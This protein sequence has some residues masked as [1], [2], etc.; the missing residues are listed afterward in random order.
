V[1]TISHTSRDAPRVLH[2]DFPV[3]ILKLLETTFR[4]RGYSWES[5]HSGIQGLH[6]ALIRDYN[7]IILSLKENS[8]DG[9]RVVRGLGRAG[10]STPVILLVPSRDLELRRQ[11]LS[12]HPNVLACLPK[13][14][15]L[16]QMEKAMD[17][18]RHPPGLKAKDKARLMEVLARIERAVDARP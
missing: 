6:L 11:E 18:L 9:L 5:T 8:I 16:R 1:Q 15:D 10:I 14:V 12:R 17:F 13:P 4:H 2:I 3:A 7:L